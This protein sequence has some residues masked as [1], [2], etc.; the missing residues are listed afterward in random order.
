MVIAT[1]DGVLL[2]SIPLGSNSRIETSIVA[3]VIGC[4]A[5]FAVHRVIPEW[6]IPSQA[7]QQVYTVIAM[8]SALCLTLWMVFGS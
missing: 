1:I 7:V 6:L 5:G 3:V 8:W 4:I 2:A